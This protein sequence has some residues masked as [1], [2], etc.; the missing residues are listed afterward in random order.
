MRDIDT[1]VVDKTGTLTLGRPALTDFLCEGLPEKEALALVAGAEQPSEHP[2][3]TAIVEGARVRGVPI[4]PA[5]DFDTVNDVLAASFTSVIR[6]LDRV[7]R[8][9]SEAAALGGGLL[10]NFSMR[11]ARA[12]AWD[13]AQRL[14]PLDAAGR[15]DYVHQLDEWVSTLAYL[16]TQPSLPVALLARLGRRLEMHDPVLVTRVL[17][18]E[19]TSREAFRAAGRRFRL[20]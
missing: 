9:A 1:L 8:W 11:W 6:D 20:A 4:P 15:R 16:I 18:G 3:A 7:S 12:T 10:F 14:E 13:S 5:R 17:L 2:I 19:I